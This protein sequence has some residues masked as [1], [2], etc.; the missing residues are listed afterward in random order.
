MDFNLLFSLAFCY[1]AI[2]P[3]QLCTWLSITRWSEGILISSCYFLLGWILQ[4]PSSLFPSYRRIKPCHL[5][6][7]SHQD[8]LAQSPAE[9][10]RSCLQKRR[11]TFRLSVG[12][13]KQEGLAQSV[14]HSSRA[15]LASCPPAGS[16]GKGCA[17][18]QIVTEQRGRLQIC[19]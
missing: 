10:T 13:F 6:T 1:V 3:V 5:L 4:T 2:A 15:Q 14:W 18:S 16:Q 11:W 17:R 12:A 9:S 19:L 8:G 7:L